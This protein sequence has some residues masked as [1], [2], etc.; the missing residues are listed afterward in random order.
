VPVP[1]TGPE[2]RMTVV[3][4]D[5]GTS[6]DCSAQ[7]L[8]DGRFRLDMSLEDSSLDA[9]DQKT[10]KELPPRFRSFR[11][12]NETVVLRDGQT[13]QLTTATEK[14]SGETTKVD[15]TLNVVK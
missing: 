13:T 10:Q 1:T 14:S 4:K 15:V 11:L 9:D 3:Y 5:V 2:G 7:T 12:S 6:I 8:D